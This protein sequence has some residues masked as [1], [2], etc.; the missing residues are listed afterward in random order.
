MN[1]W[2]LQ[3]YVYLLYI[4]SEEKY[5][6]NATKFINW[7]NIVTKLFSNKIL[8]LFIK[9][10]LKKVTARLLILYPP[11]KKKNYT[12]LLTSSPRNKAVNMT[13]EMFHHSIFNQNLEAFG[14][15]ELQGEFEGLR[16]VL[17]DKET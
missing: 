15:L 8:I 16:I 3:D 6:L 9:Q 14:I 10:N 5:F 2:E 11:N 1:S 7:F 12:F 13:F 17:V 4:Q